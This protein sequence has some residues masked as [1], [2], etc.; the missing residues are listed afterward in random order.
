MRREGKKDCGTLSCAMHVN[1]KWAFF[2]FNMPWCHQICFAKCLYSKRRDLPKHLFQ[3][4]VQKSKNFT[5]GWRA[6]SKR[7]CFFK[8]HL[9]KPFTQTFLGV[10]HEILPHE[11]EVAAVSWGRNARRSRENVC[12][13]GHE[14][15]L[16]TEVFCNPKTEG[17]FAGSHRLWCITESAI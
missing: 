11:A 7:R 15:G 17:L 9:I 10:R 2:C 16:L 5:S 3:D 6:C 4:T 14:T 13:G 12:V 1:R 8:T